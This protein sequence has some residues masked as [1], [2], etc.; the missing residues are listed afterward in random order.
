MGARTS[1]VQAMAIGVVAGVAL[2]TAYFQLRND[3]GPGPDG[4]RDREA[5]LA[6]AASALARC[7]Q[8]V[9][10]PLTVELVLTIDAHG[11]IAQVT[12]NTEP[13]GH[14]AAA[15]A[16]AALRQ[17]ASFAPARSTEVPL[18]VVLGK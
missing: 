17:A 13:R 6:K 11:Q 18:T 1:F 15:C 8:G 2:T 9:T 10:P 14:E 5:L 3:D 12:N 7:G 16:Q 4:A